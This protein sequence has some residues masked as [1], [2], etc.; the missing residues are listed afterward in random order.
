V[1]RALTGPEAPEPS[2][3]VKIFGLL[4][5]WL[6][7]L[8]LIDATGVAAQELKNLENLGSAF[9]IDEATGEHLVPWE[10][11]VLNVVSKLSFCLG[12]RRVV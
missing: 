4:C 1:T 10:L 7:C 12:P 8:T 2:D 11:R 5:T 3:H 6:A 9:Y